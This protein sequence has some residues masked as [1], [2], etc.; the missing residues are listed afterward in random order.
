VIPCCRQYTIVASSW[1]TTE[2]LHWFRAGVTRGLWSGR[3]VRA[4]V[5]RSSISKFETPIASL[6]P[7]AETP[8]F[9]IERFLMSVPSLS[10]QVTVFHADKKMAQKRRFHPSAPVI[11]SSMARHVS[12]LPVALLE[13]WQGKWIKVSCTLSTPS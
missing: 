2:S 12:E 7:A 10:W 13:P 6:F 1:W 9:S 3:G 4:S 11:K 8:R 5:E